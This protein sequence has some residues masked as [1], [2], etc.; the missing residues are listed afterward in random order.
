MTA[1]FSLTPTITLDFAYNP[2]FAQV[3]AD[4][5]V[6]DRQRSFPDLLCRKNARSFSNESTF[7]R[8]V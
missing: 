5:P 6:I 1:K 8:A 2:D 3:E 4:A 7:F